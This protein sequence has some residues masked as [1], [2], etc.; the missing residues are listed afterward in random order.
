MIRPHRRAGACSRRLAFETQYKWYQMLFRSVIEPKMQ[1]SYSHFSA[2]ASPR[3]TEREDDKSPPR[4]TV[5]RKP[6]LALWERWRAKRDGEGKRT[7]KDNHIN[8]RFRIMHPLTRPCRELS[9][10]AS[11][12]MRLNGLIQSKISPY[13]NVEKGK[14]PDERVLFQLIVSRNL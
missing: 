10:G 7:Q 8:A 1:D 4:G 13:G 11:P 5:R 14:A 3:P 12:L 6:C 9:Q 2:G